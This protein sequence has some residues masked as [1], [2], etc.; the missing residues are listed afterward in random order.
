MEKYNAFSRSD[1]FQDVVGILDQV[2]RLQNFKSSSALQSIYNKVIDLAGTGFRDAIEY[3]KHF[4]V[5]QDYCEKFFEC[6][7]KGG[8]SYELG[9][10]YQKIDFDFPQNIEGEIK[11]LEALLRIYNPFF[12]EEISIINSLIIDLKEFITVFSEYYNSK[13]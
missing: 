2:E 4:R 13:N 1:K 3:R 8:F 6:K 9:C 10:R 7:T 5:I 11:Y 12:T